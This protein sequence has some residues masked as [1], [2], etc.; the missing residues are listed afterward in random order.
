MTYVQYFGDSY[1]LAWCS[2]W[3]FWVIPYALHETYK[4]FLDVL[5]TLETIILVLFRGYPPNFLDGDS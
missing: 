2:L 4:Y 5:V 1:F 3:I